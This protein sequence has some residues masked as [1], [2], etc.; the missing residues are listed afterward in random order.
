MLATFPGLGVETD[1]VD[2]RRMPIV[3]YPYT[4]F[5]G[6][7]LSTTEVRVLRVVHAARV[8]DLG[9]LP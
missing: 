5:Y 8:R 3:R 2:V 4:V 1:D 9:N 6:V 7:D